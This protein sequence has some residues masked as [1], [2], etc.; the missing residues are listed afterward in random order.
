MEEGVRKPE[1]LKELLRSNRG[2]RRDGDGRETYS[3]D[4]ERERE[5]LGNSKERPGWISS[6][7]SRGINPYPQLPFVLGVAWS[8]C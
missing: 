4:R 2:G 8:T 7:I 6:G 1:D 5:T 3:G